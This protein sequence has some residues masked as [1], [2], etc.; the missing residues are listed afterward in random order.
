MAKNKMQGA[1]PSAQDIIDFNTALNDVDTM[2]GL[3]KNM[4]LPSSLNECETINYNAE[5]DLMKVPVI[6]NYSAL[7]SDGS[8]DWFMY[9]NVNELAKE[10]NGK[11]T[12]ISTES[13]VRKTVS[14][15][16]PTKKSAS[17][18]SSTTTEKKQKAKGKSGS[19]ADKKTFPAANKK[20]A[21]GKTPPGK[22]VKKAVSK[23]AAPAIKKERAKTE[24]KKP[25]KKIGKKAKKEAPKKTPV[26]K[27]A[28]K[29]NK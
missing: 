8:S 4:Y 28:K 15:N 22:K 24:A 5:E 23:K 9:N 19:Q 18:I 26:K 25:V 27:Q 16:K 11:D 13:E 29:K 7:G 6:L 17:N 12:T 21:T 1:Q 10:N 2:M 20:K 3:L 14:K